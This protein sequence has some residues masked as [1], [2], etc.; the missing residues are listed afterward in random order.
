MG[1]ASITVDTVATV[2]AGAAANPRARW[3]GSLRITNGSATIYLG[4]P[5]VTPSSGFQIAANTTWPAPSQPP[6]PLFSSDQIWAVT[7]SGTPVVQAFLT[8]G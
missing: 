8:G 2:V 5:G 3:S 7:A 6:V 1:S 4:G